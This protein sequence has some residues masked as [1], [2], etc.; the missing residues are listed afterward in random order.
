MRLIF[1]GLLLMLIS[2]GGAI[3]QDVEQL[4]ENRQYNTAFK[5]LEKS[6]PTNINPEVVIQKV[7]LA[8]NYFVTSIMHQVFAFKDL[9]RG[10][11]LLEIR[12]TEGN[13]DMYNF[14]VD[15]ILLDLIET[16]P[17]NMDLHRSLGMYYFDAHYRY[18]DQWLIPKDSLINLFRDHFQI[19]L[20]NGSYDH[21]SIYIIGFASLLQE[22]YLKAVEFFNQSIELKEDQPMCHY[23]L[24]YAY[25]ALDEWVDG[26]FHA[27]R[28][29]EL[30]EDN[31]WKGDAARMVAI[32][33]D[34][35]G[36]LPKSLDFFRQS[37]LLNPNNY[38]TI[39]PMLMVTSKIGNEADIRLHSK[40]LFDLDPDNPTVYQDLI[41]VY[42]GIGKQR[43]LLEFLDYQ[44]VPYSDELKVKGSIYF[45]KGVIYH[46][47]KE[48]TE[49]QKSFEEARDTFREVY[50]PGHPVFPTIESYLNGF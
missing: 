50:E 25:M 31:K 37:N 13:Y 47:L 41:E 45:Y 15:T 27:H 24:A 22:N 12:G 3:S 6:D 9:R 7:D 40:D 1:I 36:N 26:L 49:S 8:I 10:E 42:Y 5:S 4:V 17:Q 39:K 16:Y 21:E 46:D 19:A 38:Y 44:L 11:D 2:S 48:M 43:L 29:M 14:P 33:Y 18:G 30:Y 28:A 35:L 23:N 34:E 32:S 20:I